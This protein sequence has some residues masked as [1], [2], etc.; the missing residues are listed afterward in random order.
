DGDDTLT[1]DSGVNRI[2]GGRGADRLAGG[3]GLDD[4]LYRSVR[5]SRADAACDLIVDFGAGVDIDLKRIDAKQASGKNE[6]FKFLAEGDFTSAAGQLRF[7]RIDLAGIA[8]DITVI[9]ADVDGDGTADFRIEL[10]GLHALAA[11]DFV[12]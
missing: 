4:F 5:D 3:G 6:S 9:E 2:A 12:L 10:T 7:E 8:N 1:G 11:A